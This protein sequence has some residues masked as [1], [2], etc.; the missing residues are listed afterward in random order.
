ML[1]DFVLKF[2]IGISSLSALGCAKLGKILITSDA[3]RRIVSYQETKTK[4]KN[5]MEQN[6]CSLTLFR[7]I[8]G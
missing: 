8:S 7:E 3:Q 1:V 6:E 4:Q 2:A 5:E